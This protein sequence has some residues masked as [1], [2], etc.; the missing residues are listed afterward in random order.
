MELL[1]QTGGHVYIAEAPIWDND[2]LNLLR[3]NHLL[4]GITKDRLGTIASRGLSMA[5]GQLYGVVAPGLI[6]T[7]HLFRGLKRGMMIGDDRNA[8][9]KMLVASWSQRRDARL[10]GDPHNPQ[11]DYLEAPKNCVFVVAISKNERLIDFP[12]IYGWI[13]H[14][15]WVA[16]DPDEIGA[17]VDWNT[18]YDERV[19][20]ASQSG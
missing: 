20:T 18:R 2:C 6:L 14:W 11:L 13:E 9:A 8:A 17:P 15:T 19:W 1:K 7:Q 16:A 10:V 4:V 3:N 5:I 12:Q